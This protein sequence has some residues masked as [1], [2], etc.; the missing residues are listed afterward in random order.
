MS[1]VPAGCDQRITAAEEVAAVEGR[2]YDSSRDHNIA[3][4]LSSPTTMNPNSTNAF[5]QIRAVPANELSYEAFV[6][7][8]M[9]ANQPVLIQSVACDWRA[10]HEWVTHTGDVDIDAMEARFGESLVSVS[11]MH[12][13]VGVS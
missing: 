2:Q 1:C 6:S 3:H 4:L 8:F 9:S 10:T 5:K 12:R 11:T 7:Q 13:C